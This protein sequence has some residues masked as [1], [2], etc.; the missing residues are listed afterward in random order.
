MS[1]EPGSD[2]FSK[3]EENKSF[4]FSLGEFECR[5]KSNFDASLSVEAVH[6]TNKLLKF[7][8]E[9]C[10]FKPLTGNLFEKLKKLINNDI[11]MCDF[12]ILNG[13]VF[14]ITVELTI[15]DIT[16]KEQLKKVEISEIQILLMEIEELK[17]K[18]NR[19]ELREKEE[20]K[21]RKFIM[22][23]HLQEY[24]IEIKA[25]KDKL[26]D[27]EK[28]IV[29]AAQI[30]CD[31]R[32]REV[33]E[34]V[35]KNCK[36]MTENLAYQLKSLKG[37]EWMQL[38]LQTAVNEISGFTYRQ[39]V[40]HG[41]SHPNP[42]GFKGFKSLSS[43]YLALLSSAFSEYYILSVSFYQQS[44]PVFVIRQRLLQDDEF[45]VLASGGVWQNGSDIRGRSLAIIQNSHYNDYK[46]YSIY[47][48]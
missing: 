40:S 19:M 43:G 23:A 12:E 17:Q 33:V 46:T 3:A 4:S 13:D 41:D 27:E 9:K 38:A 10:F 48:N 16:I 32:I 24:Y 25:E 18:V 42:Q 14:V 35:L 47:L 30:A 22:H 26:N 11:S 21:K 29:K 7:K 44:Y 1:E 15:L 36:Q 20:E 31:E 37:K 39:G 28:E 2:V 6:R 34:P 45:K 5:L 8:S